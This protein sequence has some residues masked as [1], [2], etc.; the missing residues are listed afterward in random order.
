MRYADSGGLSTEQRAER[1][2]VRMQAAAMFER[3]LAPPEVARELRVTANSAYAWRRAWRVGGAAA[4]ASKGPGGSR[5]RLDDRQLARL[6]AAL[7]RGPAA[8]GWNDQRWTL[9][10]VA[11]L[12]EK[13]FDVRY[14]QA[15]VSLLLHRIGWS[16]QQL[17]GLGS[18]AAQ[19]DMVTPPLAT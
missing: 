19:K 1:E 2:A 5:C 7:R 13:M 4:L 12:I 15:G 10:R 14:T 16:L 6:E 3:G 17:G 11:E 18:P 8:H 9:A